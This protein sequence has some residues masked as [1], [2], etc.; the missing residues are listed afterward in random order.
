MSQD[1]YTIVGSDGHHY[2]PEDEETI[3]RW[4]RE[5][6]ANSKTMILRKGAS[7]WVKLTSLSQF[8]ELVDESAEE[9]TEVPALP[10]TP[11]ALGIANI[12]DPLGYSTFGIILGVVV[13]SFV[14]WSHLKG[15]GLNIQ[16]HKMIRSLF[17]FLRSHKKIEELLFCLFLTFHFH[18]N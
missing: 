15:D 5:G 16:P 8:A 7:T 14:L 13:G 17:L 11:K 1:K 18:K 6:K 9:S 12:T 10:K 3:Q 2:G 4:I